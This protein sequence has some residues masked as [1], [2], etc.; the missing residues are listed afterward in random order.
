MC[1]NICIYIYIYTHTHICISIYIYIYM[2]IYIHEKERYIHIDDV[3]RRRCPLSMSYCVCTR[4]CAPASAP[5]HAWIGEQAR[6]RSVWKCVC[7]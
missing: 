5:A 6:S 3:K 4:K 7:S 1:Y 2:Y